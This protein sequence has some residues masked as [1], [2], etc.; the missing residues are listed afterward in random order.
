MNLLSTQFRVFSSN[1]FQCLKINPQPHPS[2]AINTLDP[3]SRTVTVDETFNSV[4][5]TQMM[6]IIMVI[7]SVRDNPGQTVSF[8]PVICIA[9]RLSEA[10]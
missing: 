10:H 6:L 3:T 2:T 8:Y 7:C 4:L 5:D 9:S 1:S